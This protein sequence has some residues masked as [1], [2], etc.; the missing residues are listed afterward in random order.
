MPISPQCLVADNGGPFLPTTNGVNV[1]HSDPIQI[2]L[3]TPAG[4]TAW[5]LVVYG[6][7]E[8]TAPPILTNVNPSGQVVSPTATVSFTY[9]GLPTGRAIVFQST[10]ITGSN[11]AQTTFA[12]YSLTPNA[13]RVAAQG[14]TREGNPFGWAATLNPIIRRGAGFLYYDDGLAAPPTGADTIQ[15]AI[16][17]LKEHAGG[18]GNLVVY[19]DS[20]PSP[21]GNVYSTWAS[22]FTA[23]T[24]I[25]GFAIIEIDASL[26][27][28]SVPAGTYDLKD[29]KLFGFSPPAS[30]NTTLSIDAGVVFHNFNAV[31]NLI[32]ETTSP[33]APVVSLAGTQALVV[34]RN[35]QVQ[36]FGGSQPFWSVSAGG[37]L[38]IALFDTSVLFASSAVGAIVLDGT[39]SLS[40]NGFAESSVSASCISGPVGATA[41]VNVDDTSAVGLQPGLLGTFNTTLLSQAQDVAY[42]PALPLSWSPVPTQVAQ[43]LDILKAGSGGGGGGNVFVYR[44]GATP[45]GNVFN[46]FSAAYAARQAVQGFAIIEVDSTAAPGVVLPIGGNAATVT[47]TAGPTVTVTGLTGMTASVVGGPLSIIGSSQSTNNGTFIIATFISSSSVTIQNNAAVTDSGGDTWSLPYNMFDTKL[48]GAPIPGLGA[49]ASINFNNNVTFANLADIENLT[50]GVGNTVVP[51]ISVLGSNSFTILRNSQITVSASQPFWAVLTS[52]TLN[53]YLLDASSL[54]TSSGPVI[55]LTSALS[56]ITELAKSSIGDLCLAGDGFSNLQCMHDDSSTVG[57][58]SLVVG[59]LN[60]QPVSLAAQVSY[61]PAT[62]GN[63]SPAPSLVAP[64]L[65]QLAARSGGGSPPLGPNASW[66]VPH[67]WIDPSFGSDSNN[68]TSIGTP[69]KT[70]RGLVKI[71]GTVEPVLQQATAITFLGSQQIFTNGPDPIVFRPILGENNPGPVFIEGTPFVTNTGVSIVSVTSKNR[72]AGSNTP[73]VIDLGLSLPQRLLRNTSRGSEAA[74]YALAPPFVTANYVSQP[75]LTPT[76][77]SPFTAEDDGWLPGDLVDVLAPTQLNI[78]EVSCVSN[79]SQRVGL[80]NINM[81]QPTVLENVIAINCRMSSN[82]YLVRSMRVGS[83]GVPA[84]SASFVNCF[85][86]GVLQAFGAVEFYAGYTGPV[87]A[88]DQITG[89]VN[90]N[91]DFIMG[92][93]VVVSG[94]ARFNGSVYMDASFTMNDGYTQL[95]QA[96]GGP[97][98]LYGSTN[99][100]LNL[101]GKSYFSNATAAGTFVPVLTAAPFI[102]GNIFLNFFGNAMSSSGSTLFSGIAITPANLDAAAGASGFGGTAFILGG[103]SISIFP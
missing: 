56:S 7:D 4:V 102:S 13:D 87:A 36:V 57:N 70:W 71:L 63:W 62:P 2:R 64:A 84:Y 93:A 53:L 98:I 26:H 74:V 94:N 15:A 82:N 103:A 39:S 30:V 1:T 37:T 18:T 99:A 50:I 29:T 49:N 77:G 76:P 78:V 31:E 46:S 41:S 85:S 66:T 16:D 25:Q 5:Y 69:L 21:S 9:P 101:N 48:L 58:T 55:S 11:T 52:Q 44:V 14:E 10:V 75:I 96:F 22:A 42:S 92:N 100:R 97:Y 61:S 23:R 35:A 89:A 3:Q 72:N 88:T 68:G 43:A 28:C 38:S 20:E 86:T 54:S 73:L 59:T 80:Y 27:S 32:I 24:S 90:F 67:W 19:R 47:V 45:S 33:S 17:F 8:I 79:T 12:I 40:V 34:L 95:G 81:N 51:T 60:V 65:D 6:T 83:G 91:A